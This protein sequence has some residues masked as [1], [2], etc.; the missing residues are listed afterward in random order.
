MKLFFSAFF[1]CVNSVQT[2]LTRVRVLEATAKTERIKTEWTLSHFQTMKSRREAELA[3]QLLR[4]ARS[5]LARKKSSLNF[6][7]SIRS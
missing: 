5:V 1:L 3:F 2:F 7:L 6:Q 4:E